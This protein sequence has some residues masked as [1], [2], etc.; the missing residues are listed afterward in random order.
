MAIALTDEHL[1]LAQ[2]A[3]AFLEEHDAR[4][5]ARAAFDA[6]DALP[7]FWKAIADV[8]WFGL[9]LP[10]QYGGSGYGLPELAVVLDE[11]GQVCAPGPFLPTVVASVSSR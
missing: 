3:R 10:E 11:M 9:H 1:E 6:D 2:V 4:G 5:A 8:E 7:A